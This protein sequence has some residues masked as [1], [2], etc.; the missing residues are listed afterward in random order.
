MTKLHRKTCQA[1]DKFFWQLLCCLLISSSLQAS[2]TQSQAQTYRFFMG[3]YYPSI[4]NL[5]TRTDFQVAINFWLEEFGPGLG[6]QP[7]KAVLYDD[8]TSLKQA[9]ESHELDFIMAPPILLAKHF[10]RG[11]LADGFVGTSVDGSA[12]GTALLVRQ[13]QGIGD[14]K[15]LSGKRL[16]LPENDDLAALY[17]DSLMLK[18]YRKHYRQ[19][20]S[21]VQTKDKQSSV[22]LALFFK[23]ADVGMSYLEI[24][25]LMVEMNPQIKHS[26]AILATFPTK[27][28]NYGYFHRD[29]PADLRAKLTE[30]VAELNHQPRSQQILNDLRMSSLIPCAVSELQ[31]FDEL[32]AEQL[33][34]EKGI[35][36]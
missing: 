1:F 36:P 34:L 17:L 25:N 6:L 12:Y 9:F 16:L 35:K 2:Q 15:K 27:S 10:Q 24:Y 29:F 3:V 19:V 8:V 13:D 20:F 23:Q 18:N 4:T 30:T 7:I 28:P 14:I 21:Q 22:V 5:V 31:Q 32:V 33:S 11:L 26:V